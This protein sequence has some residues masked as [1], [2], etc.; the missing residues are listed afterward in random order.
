MQRREHL[1][2]SEK[3]AYLFTLTTNRKHVE[4]RLQSVKHQ[5][6]ELNREKEQLERQ[7]DD[8]EQ[9]MYWLQS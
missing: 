9:S 8:I 4:H 7:L 6:R 2:P 1:K 5:L 3:R